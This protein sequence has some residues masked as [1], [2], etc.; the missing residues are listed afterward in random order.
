MDAGHPGDVCN[1]FANGSRGAAE[2]AQ[3][4]LIA[5]H[6][7]SPRANPFIVQNLTGWPASIRCRYGPGR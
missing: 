5:A 7:A 4:N 6:S 3:T 2:F 1:S